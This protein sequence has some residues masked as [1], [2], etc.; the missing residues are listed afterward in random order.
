MRSFYQTLETAFRLWVRHLI[1]P[2]AFGLLGLSIVFSVSHNLNFAYTSIRLA[3]SFALARGYPLYSL[4]DHPPW[5]MVGYGPF[6]P[7]AYLPSIFAK[8]PVAA[9]SAA[10]ISAYAYI[11]VPVGLLAAL[12]CRRLDPSNNGARL[13]WLPVF[14]F[15]GLLA[16]CVPSLGYISTAVHVD[17]PALG[18]FL[19]ACYGVLRAE[20]GDQRWNGRCI[21]LA[22]IAAGLSASCKITLL[23]GLFGIALYILWALNWRRA[24]WFA[25]SAALTA[26]LIYG[27]IIVRDGFP[28]VFL[29]FQVLQKFPLSKH[30]FLSQFRNYLKD[31]GVAF[32]AILTLLRLPIGRTADSKTPPA[33]QMVWFF[34]FI[35]VVVLPVSVA[36][37]AKYGG[38]V[39]SRAIFTLPLTLAAIFAMWATI[40]R[41]N[42]IGSLTTG[43]ALTG[44]ILIVALHVPS[45]LK[46]VNF[47]RSLMEESYAT[48]RAY[49]SRCYFP[50]DPLAHLLA[51][52]RFRPNMDVIYSYAVAGFPVNPTAFESSMPEGL[53][54]VIY[55]SSMKHW[56]LSEIRRLLPAQ[57]VQTNSLNLA[58]Q[59]VW[60]RGI[61]KSD[62]EKEKMTKESSG[63]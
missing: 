9:V 21:A 40:H 22:G 14:L 8:D 44:G 4:P 38:D 7:I 2:C 56:G 10:T 42:V 20:A 61:T 31:Y 48:V 29:N 62:S 5:V 15:F 60:D 11:L 23:A 46:R 43:A 26:C 45:E 24:A 52:D 58:L 34:L 39:N 18:L 47:G 49:P 59:E 37:V 25:F 36:S 63:L 57:S 12:F 50:Y 30:I 1:T 6:Y 16:N 35:A 55:P 13:S 33:I 28:A 19:M 54:Y 3:P 27:W 41:A 32:L 17:A 53:R 51:G